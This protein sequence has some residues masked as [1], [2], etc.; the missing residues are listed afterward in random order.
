[1][2]Q[3]H[4]IQSALDFL[5]SRSLDHF[6]VRQ[7]RVLLACAQSAQTVRGLAKSMG[8][9]RPAITRAADTLEKSK[10]LIRSP[11]KTDKRSVLLALTPAGKKFAAHFE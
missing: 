2:A 1:M 9:S 5:L 11:D 7:M 4:A 3:K 8:V 10:F 6:S